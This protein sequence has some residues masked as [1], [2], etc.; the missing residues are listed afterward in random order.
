MRVGLVTVDPASTVADARAAE[1]LGFDLLACGEHLF[2]HRPT[3]NPFIQLAAAAG[4]TDRIR[5]VSSIALL[6]LYPAALVAKLAA[7]LDQVSSGRFELGLGAGGEY[8]PEFHAAGVDPSTRFRRL[9]EGLAVLRGLFTGAPLRFEGEFAS[10][11]DLTLEPPPVQAGGPPIWLAGRKDR[12]IRRAGRYADVWLPYLVTPELLRTGLEKV[13]V[14]AADAGRRP[15]AVRGA[16][17]AWTCVDQDSEWARR[18][19]IAAVSAAYQQDFEPLADRYL[20]LG[21]PDAVVTRLREFADAGADSVLIQL[22]VEPDERERVL[23][24]I[25][26][27]VLPKLRG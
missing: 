25:A 3:P 12:A 5:L 22:A 27:H 7:T 16:I 10:I 21:D 14:A 23:A 19:G 4:V 9:D 13:R 17:F 11:R 18:Q 26:E 2:F 8:P 15:G 20:V 6:P 24:S 1:D